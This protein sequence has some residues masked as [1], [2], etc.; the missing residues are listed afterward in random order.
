M[1]AGPFVR[2]ANLDELKGSGPFALSANGVDVVVIRTPSGLRAFEGRCPH[3][4]ALLGEGELD[5]DRLVCRNHRWRFKVDSGRRDG[6]P[7]CLASCPAVEKD[8]AIFLDVSGLSGDAKLAK[9]KRVLEDLPGPKGWPLLGNLHQL[10]LPKLHLILEAWAE[11]YGQAYLFRMGTRPVV[12]ISNPTWCEQMLRARPETFRRDANM[13]KVMAEMAFEGVFSA[14]GEAWRPQRRLSVAALAQRN[15]IRD[16]NSARPIFG[17]A[18][19][20]VLGQIMR[21]SSA[22][23]SI[24]P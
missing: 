12:T 2:A 17:T 6:G 10:D 22:M 15:L 3:Q 14:E 1:K 7:E 13:A 16:Y 11:K 24:P 20:R 5:G 8:G 4:G 21:F 23:S 19:E 18:Q 9:A